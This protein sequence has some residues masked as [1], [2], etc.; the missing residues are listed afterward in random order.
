MLAATE[1]ALVE[2]NELLELGE[3]GLMVAAGRATVTDNT[4]RGCGAD[5]LKV[6]GESCDMRHVPE[7]GVGGRKSS[8]FQVGVDT[9]FGPPAEI[10]A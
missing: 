5:G 3:G 6:V 7:A 2:G 8:S 10:G 1:Q 4:I 9:G